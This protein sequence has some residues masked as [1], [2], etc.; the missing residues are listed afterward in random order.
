M[1]SKKRRDML[2]T[3]LYP[4]PEVE[5]P[6]ID[7]KAHIGTA[8]AAPLSDSS[9]F[10]QPHPQFE[11]DLTYG[12]HQTGREPGL[13]A[14]AE[15]RN[16]NDT[17]RDSYTRLREWPTLYGAAYAAQSMRRLCDSFIALDFVLTS[18]DEAQSIAGTYR[19][20]LTVRMRPRL[21]PGYK[22]TIDMLKKQGV[23]PKH[24]MA[25]SITRL[26]WIANKL[27]GITTHNHV[28]MDDIRRGIFDRMGF[29]FPMNSNIDKPLPY[30]KIT[31]RNRTIKL[32]IPSKK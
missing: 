15:T 28:D 4:P 14:R 12:G 25:A 20:Q 6:E 8:P 17:D 31:F 27:G 21:S 23:T 9:V 16:V 29:P 5:A 1:S 11:D 32:R 18:A 10:Y 26:R 19:K 2:R 30:K 7:H 22:P 24:I 3:N 13:M